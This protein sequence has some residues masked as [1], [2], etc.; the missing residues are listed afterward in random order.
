MRHWA[1]LR[2][3]SDCLNF[4]YFWVSPASVFVESKSTACMM[5]SNW[6]PKSAKLLS[7]CLL[8]YLLKQ[9]VAPVCLGGT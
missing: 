7:P 2:I 8:S 4:I 5:Y 3:M 6:L 9:Q 1:S